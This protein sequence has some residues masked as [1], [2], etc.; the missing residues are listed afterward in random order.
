MITKEIRDLWE[1]LG[2]VAI[3]NDEK[4]EEK[5]ITFPPGTPREDIWHWFE[6]YLG[7]SIAELMYENPANDDHDYADKLERALCEIIEIQPLDVFGP[8][9]DRMRGIARE[10]LK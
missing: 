1:Q 2:D 5:F 8:M 10:A 7:V 9:S 6:D 4:I 3:D